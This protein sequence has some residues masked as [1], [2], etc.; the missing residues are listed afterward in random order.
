MNSTTDDIL[1]LLRTHFQFEQIHQANV[2]DRCNDAQILDKTANVPFGIYQ[3]KA[4]HARN[5]CMIIIQCNCENVHFSVL[6]AF[7]V[8]IPRYSSKI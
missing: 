1:I 3:E 4:I 2:T 7:D 8:Y 5:A 6:I